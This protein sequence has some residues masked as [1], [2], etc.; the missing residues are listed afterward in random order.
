MRR[1]WYYK[2]ALTESGTKSRSVRERTLKTK[3]WKNEVIQGWNK[4]KKFFEVIEPRKKKEIQRR[5]RAKGWTVRRKAHSSK[6][7]KK[8]PEGFAYVEENAKA[9]LINFNIRVWSWLRTNAGGMLN[10]CKSNGDI[11]KAC[12]LNILVADGWVTREEPGSYR[13]IT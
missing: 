8:K 13:G 4:P 12:F 6:E 11:W 9:F 5:R 10:T 2:Q 7:R 3:H 1:G